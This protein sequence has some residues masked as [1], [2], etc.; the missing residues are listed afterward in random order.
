MDKDL[1]WQRLKV[2]SSRLS[3]HF[4]NVLIFLTIIYFLIIVGQSMY[5][6]YQDNKKI[7]QKKA[8]IARLRTQVVF[9]ENQNLYYQTES[10]R[11]KEARKK[12]GMIKPGENVVALDRSTETAQTLVA[13]KEEK[14]KLPNYLKWW[15]YFLGG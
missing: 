15:N 14:I 11:E 10:F 4:G 1:H 9:L 7:D 6:S 5:N 8:E 13:P 3:A 2:I 12:L